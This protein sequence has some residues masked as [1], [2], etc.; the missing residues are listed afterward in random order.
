MTRDRL[1]HGGMRR[2][3]MVA[4][5]GGAAIALAATAPFAVAARPTCPLGPNIPRSSGVQW[6][7]SV[8][9]LPAGGHKGITSSYTHGHGTWSGGR[10]KGAVCHQ[11]SGGGVATRHVVTRVSPAP[12]RLRGHVTRLGKL[13]VELVVPLVVTGSDDADCARGTHGTVTLFASYYDVHV[14]SAV[15]RFGAGCAGHDHTYR[16]SSLKVLITRS[17][18]QVD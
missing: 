12:A 1:R 2:R 10:A 7:F 9:G 3:A 17:G 14:D 8:S 13:G 4:A 6:G 11:D 15:L 5:L 18:A 16:G